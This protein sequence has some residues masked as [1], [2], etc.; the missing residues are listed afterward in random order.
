MTQHV[1]WHNIIQD[2]L[3]KHNKRPG[4]N[5]VFKA[6]TT[7][8]MEVLADDSANS[9]SVY[10]DTTIQLDFRCIKGCIKYQVYYE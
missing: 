4:F 3:Q 2:I 7:N 8:C 9:V 10:V 6:P 5:I 1:A